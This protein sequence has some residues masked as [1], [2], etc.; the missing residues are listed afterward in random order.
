MERLNP[1]LNESAGRVILAFLRKIWH[2]Y[3][4]RNQQRRELR[5]LAQMSEQQLK[6]IGLTP[7]ECIERLHNP[8]WRR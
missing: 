2:G 6:D 3:R 7:S 1:G 5:Y 8:M 4:S